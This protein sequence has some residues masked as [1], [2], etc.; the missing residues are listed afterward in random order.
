MNRR[1]NIPEKLSGIREEDIPAMA[2]K[3]DSEANPIYPVPVLMN[4][5]ELEH[6]YRMIME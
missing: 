5:G 1:L 3:A 4:A 6:Y 2:Q